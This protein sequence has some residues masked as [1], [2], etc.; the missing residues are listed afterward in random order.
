ML[1]LPL[2]G[3]TPGI[4]AKSSPAASGASES[5]EASSAQQ[6]ME[7]GKRAYRQKKFQQAADA[8]G[9][10]Y[11]L[12]PT[13]LSALYNRAYALRKAG[14][15]SGAEKLYRE[16]LARQPGDMD[17]LFGWAETLRL[18]KRDAEAK[19][20]FEAY[21]AKEQRK[22][23]ARYLAYA[24]E[25]ILSFAA[26]EVAGDEVAD[27]TADNNVA[28][29][30]A[31]APSAAV[32]SE[33]KPIDAGQKAAEDLLRAK[34][35]Y[36]SKDYL[37]AA[38]KY[39]SA[40]QLAP[41]NAHA[42]YR[43]ALSW[44]KAGYFE[45]AKMRYEQYLK[46]KPRDLD[47]VYG[48]AETYRLLDNKAESLR[49]FSKYASMENRPSEKKFVERAQMW[50][51][52]FQEAGALAVDATQP[53]PAAVDVQ[54]QSTKA[55]SDNPLPRL[56][57]A[58]AA[59][60]FT[61]VAASVRDAVPTPGRDLW[62]QK[63]LRAADAA[64]AANEYA[65]AAARY[66]TVAQHTVTGDDTWQ[67]AM[68]GQLRSLYATRSWVDARRVERKVE[69]NPKFSSML[70]ECQRDIVEERA[71]AIR[72]MVEEAM[73][74]L[75][76]AMQD[77]DYDTAKELAA[78]V[79]AL[80]TRQLEALLML[81]A[82]EAALDASDDALAAFTRAAYLFPQSCRPHWAMARLAEVRGDKSQARN[83]YL[84]YLET[85]CDDRESA[86]AER[87]SHFTAQPLE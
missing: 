26:P 49:Y 5:N 22:D 6:W 13:S 43:S 68:A 34:K 16:V 50:V 19:S 28:A 77:Q 18:L 20:A 39:E 31:V 51:K 24:R 57:A 29:S 67:A 33:A 7:R 11:R 27:Q 81:G 10:A 38:E 3:T 87:A 8:Y 41:Q 72:V 86:Q 79:L 12:D 9:E 75:R 52:K 4:A 14:D 15:F 58:P 71:E 61:P 25:Q 76:G 32:D 1:L 56:F 83:H 46:L 40:F 2:G 69:H 30:G 47:A 35:A 23:K 45:R 17:A 65:T 66:A 80:D 37:A 48:L 53:S 74:E 63:N 42:L 44:R 70:A 85:D 78:H 60:T 73:E 36:R 59:G 21:V 82:A 55:S 62:A 64:F 84:R 54:T